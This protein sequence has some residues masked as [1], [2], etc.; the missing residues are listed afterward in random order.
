MKKALAV[1]MLTAMILSTGCGNQA[2]DAAK[3]AQQ[4]VEQTADAAKDKANQAAD[5]AAKKADEMKSDAAAKVDEAKDAANQAADDVA[6]KADEMKSDAAAKV[7]E[8]AT[9]MTSMMNERVIALN[10][11]MPGASVED[12]QAMFGEATKVEG[13]VMTFADGLKVVLDGAKKVKSIS[14]VVDA[15]ET[16]EGMYV[17]ASEYSLN[18]NCGP[19]DSVRKIANG[20]EYE[21]NSGDKKSIVVYKAENGIITEITCTLK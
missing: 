16:P 20:A 13:N 11:L 12:V 2:Q 8:M 10:G 9:D 21:Y 5:D 4:K 19:A 15:F 14:T 3:D 17:G 18:D 7:D 1:L 6:K